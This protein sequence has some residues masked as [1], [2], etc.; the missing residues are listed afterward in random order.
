[1]AT[2]TKADKP[3]S[4][5]QERK[6]QLHERIMKA[7]NEVPDMK[8]IKFS[9]KDSKEADKAIRELEAFERLHGGV[10]MH[11]EGNG[12]TTVYRDG[13]VISVGR[14]R[15]MLTDCGEGVVWSNDLSKGRIG[16]PKRKK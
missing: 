4:T 6:D 16:V 1:M 8:D 9:K 13:T 10:I 14:G 7:F 3:K 5:E 12:G 15:G 11:H 2:N